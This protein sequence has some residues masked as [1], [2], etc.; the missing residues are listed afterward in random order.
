[1]SLEHP[2]PRG[3]TS[4]GKRLVLIGA[5]FGWLF[6][7]I[8]MSQMTLLS[9]AATNEFYRAGHLRAEG[10]LDWK[11][12]LV[13]RANQ[14]IETSLNNEQ[15]KAELKKHNPRWFARYSSIFL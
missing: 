3:L 8:Q 15:V 2:A 5:F 12:L 6:A 13:G 7:G 4:T 14:P 9:N 11:N 1:M 10:R